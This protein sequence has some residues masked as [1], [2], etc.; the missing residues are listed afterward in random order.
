[1]LGEA[2]QA[3]D[4]A[5]LNTSYGQRRNGD[6]QLLNDIIELDKQIK[7][8]KTCEARFDKKEAELYSLLDKIL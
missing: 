4:H 2:E 6:H 3:D 1:M 7:F 5:Q 8:L